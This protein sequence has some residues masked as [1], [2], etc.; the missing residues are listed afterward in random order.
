MAHTGCVRLPD[1]PRTHTHCFDVHNRQSKTTKK[2][3]KKERNKFDFL[4]WHFILS[5][6]LLAIP[7][8]ARIR[9]KTQ[10]KLQADAVPI[11]QQNLTMLEWNLCLFC[12]AFS[13][14]YFS[15][16]FRFFSR[17]CRVLFVAI[18]RFDI[19]PIFITIFIHREIVFFFFFF[20]LRQ[21]S[22]KMHAKI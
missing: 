2:Q 1:R 6:R 19:L 3:N 15:R 14:I 9:T 13:L 8:L 12:I 16:F 7:L 18:L 4:S 17:R 20:F 21:T 5:V 11:T 10:Y 22:T